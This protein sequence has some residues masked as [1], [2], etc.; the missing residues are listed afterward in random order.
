MSYTM[1]G[2]NLGHPQIQLKRGNDKATRKMKGKPGILNAVLG[3]NN[4]E[5]IGHGTFSS[6]VKT[7]ILWEKVSPQARSLICTSTRDKIWACIIFYH[8]IDI[9]FWHANWYV[10]TMSKLCNKHYM[11]RIYT[12]SSCY[13][14]ETVWN[15]TLQI[16]IQSNILS[17]RKE[18]VQ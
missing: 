10:K 8:L 5:L 7:L 12:P 4:I 1:G 3:K 9:N 2:T 16:N 11:K 18:H 6:K 13:T 15:L 17:L 14:Q